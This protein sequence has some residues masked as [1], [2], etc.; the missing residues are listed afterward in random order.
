MN[1]HTILD[2]D[3]TDLGEVSGREATVGEELSHDGEFRGSVDDHPG[4]VEGMVAHGV[5]YG[6]VM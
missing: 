6:I 2:V 5:S 3:A 4:S 1:H